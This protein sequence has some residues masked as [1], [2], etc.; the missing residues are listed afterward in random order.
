MGDDG[1]SEPDNDYDGLMSIYKKL[2]DTFNWCLNNI[3]DTDFET[4]VDFLFFNTNNPN[5]K[6]INGKEY[7]RAKGVPSWL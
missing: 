7:R 1:E 6:I 4:L 2:V 5:V 3:D